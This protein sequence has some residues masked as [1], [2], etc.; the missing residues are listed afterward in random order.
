[1]T[2]QIAASSRF[3]VDM[4]L[5]SNA[6]AGEVLEFGVARPCPTSLRDT[7]IA[8]TGRLPAALALLNGWALAGVA[9]ERVRHDASRVAELP[10]KDKADRL[11]N[12]LLKRW[13]NPTA[14]GLQ[15]FLWADAPLVQEGLYRRLA[16]NPIVD[17]LQQIRFTDDGIVDTRRLH[18]I[19]WTAIRGAE[20]S[21]AVDGSRLETMLDAYVRDLAKTDAG[22]MELTHVARLHRS[23]LTRLVRSGT[24]RPGVLYAWLHTG[25]S[26]PA[27]VPDPVAYAGAAVRDAEDTFR[28]QSASELAE[29]YGRLRDR[30]KQ[31]GERA[32]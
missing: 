17:L 20:P 19:A 4:S 15:V 18:D 29:A 6:E 14:P 2:S 10:V 7:I 30:C 8:D 22:T 12:V 21:I 32:D 28:V 16:T 24:L 13:R 27:D 26:E 1:M 31:E 25:R 3:T 11:A 9:W 5:L 23:L